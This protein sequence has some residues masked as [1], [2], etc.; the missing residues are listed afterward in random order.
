MDI[1]TD[2]PENSYRTGPSSVFYIPRERGD[3]LKCLAVTRETGQ[4]LTALYTVLLTLIISAVWKVATIVVMGFFS[5][6]TPPGTTPHASAKIRNMGIVG[7]WNAR[8]PLEALWFSGDYFR[9][10]CWSP[11]RGARKRGGGLL[12]LAAAGVAVSYFASIF[13]AGK[14]VVGSMA[15][16]SA[17]AVYVPTVAAAAGPGQGDVADQM[18][19]Q[20]LRAPAAIRAIGSAEA[21]Q[22]DTTVRKRVKLDVA[23]DSSWFEYEYHVTGYDMG[24]Q[25]WPGLKQTVTGRC[26]TDESWFDD[27]DRK[28][29]YD[30]YRPWGLDNQTR[31]VVMDGE[32]KVAPY[33][34]ALSFEWQDADTLTRIPAKDLR[35]GILVH[36]SHRASFRSSSDPWYAT[37]EYVETG[38]TSRLKTPPGCRVASRRPALACT[39]TDVWS[40]KGVDYANIYDLSDPSIIDFPAA[41]FIQLQLDFARPRII[42]VINA[43]GASSLQSAMTFVDQFFDAETASL[44]RDIERL[45]TATWIASC[46]TFRNMVMVGVGTQNILNAATDGGAQPQAGVDRFIV[47]TPRVMALRFSILVAVPATLA[48]LSL[49]LLGEWVVRK[50]YPEYSERTAWYEAA[51]LYARRKELEE[52]LKRRKITDSEAPAQYCKSHD[53]PNRPREWGCVVGHEAAA[54]A[55]AATTPPPAPPSPTPPPSGGH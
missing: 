12:F 33:A 42:D 15:P 41:W 55:A 17:K 4:Y 47:S 54:A 29:D 35:Y 19:L 22:A 37:E 30:V 27:Y 21:A 26:E 28:K 7:F 11:V 6:R 31:N 39:Q 3:T 24:L 20:A 48:A 13:V 50:C 18:R 10:V 45:L 43:A 8:E 40:Y 16:A 44:H 5:P 9:R 52:E 36:S 53:R 34:T 14:L 23:S 46:H 2:V 51:Y 1:F 25:H 49:L 38:D 32:R